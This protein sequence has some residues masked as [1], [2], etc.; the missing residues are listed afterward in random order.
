MG[1]ENCISK[2]LL[3]QTYLFQDKYPYDRDKFILTAALFF[4]IYSWE[5]TKAL[6]Y[7]L[8]QNGFFYHQWS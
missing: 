7:L 5:T 2:L 1:Y 3:H 8:V 4:F 6:F